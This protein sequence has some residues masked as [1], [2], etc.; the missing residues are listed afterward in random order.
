MG[1]QLPLKGRIIKFIYGNGEE[2]AKDFRT[3]FKVTT[4]TNSVVIQSVLSLKNIL[5]QEYYSQLHKK[6]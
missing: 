4:L 2:I 6:Q 1:V 3:Y 5:T